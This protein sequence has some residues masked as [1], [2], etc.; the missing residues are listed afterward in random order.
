LDETHGA[1]L[2][3]GWL[4]LAIVFLVVVVAGAH[5]LP[6]RADEA[7]SL[8]DCSFRTINVTADVGSSPGVLDMQPD[9][10]GSRLV[11]FA[12]PTLTGVITVSTLVSVPGSLCHFWSGPAFSVT[13]QSE[14]TPTVSAPSVSIPYP[15]SSVHGPTVTVALTVSAYVTG[16]TLYES[17]RDAH[18]FETWRHLYLPSPR[19]TRLLADCRSKWIGLIAT[20]QRVAAISL[21]VARFRRQPGRWGRSTG[22][23][24][25]G[26]VH[27]RPADGVGQRADHIRVDGQAVAAGQ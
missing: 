12:R 9:G 1:H 21:I 20:Q 16:S 8:L 6:T 4:G 13:A 18:L 27:L 17:D 26:R 10:I 23:R 3:A 15:V 11:Y 5:T 25:Y 14:F 2:L 7:E 19:R 24:A 22:R